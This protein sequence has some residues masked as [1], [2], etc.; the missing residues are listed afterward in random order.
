MEARE[1]LG[2]KKKRIQIRDTMR[3]RVK[4]GRRTNERKDGGKREAKESNS[5]GLGKN[6]ENDEERRQG[7]DVIE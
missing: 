1:G 4:E 5:K 7:G 6:K 2:R 3:K